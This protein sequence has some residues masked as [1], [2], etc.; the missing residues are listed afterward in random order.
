M[1]SN[2]YLFH[3]KGVVDVTNFDA[4]S[5]DDSLGY[6]CSCDITVLKS[7]QIEI[8]SDDIAKGL[9]ESFSVSNIVAANNN[10]NNYNPNHIAEV[11]L[12]TDSK[13]LRITFQTQ[14]SK[15]E[16]W[17]VLS[18]AKDNLKEIG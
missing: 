6:M 12:M 7:G 15:K 9:L 10:I 5:P 16:F 14:E 4:K 2:N 1:S 18:T 3:G 17:R 11:S 8:Y 13:D